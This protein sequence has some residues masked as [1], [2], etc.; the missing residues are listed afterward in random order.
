MVFP[1][2]GSD[3][4]NEMFCFIILPPHLS[5][6]LSSPVCAEPVMLGVACWYRSSS[7][8]GAGRATLLLTSC[9]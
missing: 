1:D 4:P 3:G 9:L 2:S 7:S 8:Q 5:V 6:P